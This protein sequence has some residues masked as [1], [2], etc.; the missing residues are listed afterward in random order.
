MN[1]CSPLRVGDALRVGKTTGSRFARPKPGESEESKIA[2]VAQNRVLPMLGESFAERAG[3]APCL[4]AF[5]S[6]EYNLNIDKNASLTLDPTFS[7]TVIPLQ[8][9]LPIS[10]PQ[11]ETTAA[12]TPVPSPEHFQALWLSCR[13]RLVL[14]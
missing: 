8:K 11:Q 5:G 3:E 14:H 13:R 7:L 6:S 4:T 12:T 2:R 1:G 10:P 9:R